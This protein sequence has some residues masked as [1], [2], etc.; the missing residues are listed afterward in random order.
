MIEYLLALFI[1]TLPML[2]AALV[3]AVLLPSW[4][5]NAGVLAIAAAIL[6][7]FWV[8]YWLEPATAVAPG[9]AGDGAGMALL[10]LVTQAFALTMAIYLALFILWRMKA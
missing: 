8:W 5:W 4:R 2:G 3:L 7:G 6:L 9:E 1:F 10:W